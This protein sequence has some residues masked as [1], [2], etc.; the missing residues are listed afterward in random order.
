MMGRKCEH[1]LRQISIEVVR[2]CLSIREL[3]SVSTSYFLQVNRAG[4]MGEGKF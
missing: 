3:T 1:N 4:A 2:E